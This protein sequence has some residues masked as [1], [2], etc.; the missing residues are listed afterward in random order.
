M[1]TKNP[2]P[3]EVVPLNN[4]IESE[5]QSPEPLIHY[6][7]NLRVDKLYA[8]LPIYTANRKDT[9]RQGVF[10]LKSIGNVNQICAFISGTEYCQ[11]I[12]TGVVLTSRFTAQTAAKTLAAYTVGAN[13]GSFI[14]SANVLVTVSTTHSFT[15]TVSYTDESNTARTLTLNFSQVTGTFITAITNVL[16][17]GAYEGV[18]LHIRCKAGTTI[19]IASAAGGTYTTVTYNIEGIIQ[20]TN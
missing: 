3:E 4:E 13:D 17:A 2:K 9:P 7:D 14:V 8:G 5:N 20:Q 16:G 19:T 6:F 18:P 15:V 10:Y 1:T 11:S 12:G